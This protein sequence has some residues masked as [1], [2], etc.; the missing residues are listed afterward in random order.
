[1]VTK[2]KENAKPV[3]GQLTLGGSMALDWLKSGTVVF[4]ASIMIADVKAFTTRWDIPEWATGFAAIIQPAEAHLNPVLVTQM[5]V[6]R[7]LENKCVEW[8]GVIGEGYMQTINEVQVATLDLD[9]I[10]EVLFERTGKGKFDPYNPV[11]KKI[12]KTKS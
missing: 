12:H 6:V 11:Q 2:K 7:W 3:F 4:I 10:P 1:M 9:S 8:E 5:S